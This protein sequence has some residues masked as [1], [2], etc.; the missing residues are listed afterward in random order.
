ML[1]RSPR[2]AWCDYCKLRWGVES[3]R[4][5]MQATWQITTRRKN[6]KVIIR[7]YCHACAMEVQTWPDGSTWTLNEQIEYA[8]GNQTLDV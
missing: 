2:G 7:N 8:K 5:Q 3:L 4:G 6:G 1:S